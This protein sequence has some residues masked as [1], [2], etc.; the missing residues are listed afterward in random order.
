ME[1]LLKI[2]SDLRKS[3]AQLVLDQGELD[4][5]TYGEA[6][7]P[8][9][10][11]AIRANKEGLIEYLTLLDN[12]SDTQAA[13]P[14]Q[15]KQEAY[16]VS[17]AQGRMWMLCQY[18]EESKAYQMP[19]QVRLSGAYDIENFKKA[20]YAVIER[21]D[22]LRTVFFETDTGAVMQQVKEIED[23]QFS[24]DYHDLRNESDAEGTCHS[25]ITADKQVAFNLEQ[26]PLLRA[27]LFRLEEMEYEFYF[28]MHHIISDGWSMDILS[29]DVLA[30]YEAYQ[31]N[32]ESNVPELSIQYKDYAAWYRNESQQPAFDSHKKYWEEKLGGE[33]P[34]LDLPTRKQRP[35]IKTYKGAALQTYLSKEATQALNKWVQAHGGSL[36]TAVLAVYNVLFSKYTGQEDIMVGT[37][38]SG[39]DHSDLLNQIGLYVNTLVLRNSIDANDSFAQFYKKLCESTLNDFEHQAYSFDQIIEDLNIKGDPSRSALFDVIFTLQNRV[40]EDFEAT[41]IKDSESI[42]T[43]DDGTAKF[44]LQIIA[45]EEGEQLSLKLTYNTDVYGMGMLKRFLNHFKQLIP[46]LIDQSNTP[47]KRIEYLSEEERWEILGDFN[48]TTVAY[49]KDVTL[50][51]LFR[52][53]VSQTPDAVAVIYEDREWTYQELEDLSNKMAHFLLSNYEIYKGDFIGIRIPR[54]EWS[55]L[56]ILAILK[57][58]AAYVPIDMD[59]PTERIE[60][61]ESDSNCS[62]T[63][64]ADVLERFK[65]EKD[66]YPASVPELTLSPNQLAY[67]MYTSGSTGRPKGVMIEQMGIIRLVKNT[68]YVGLKRGTVVLGLS[69]FSFDGSTF[70]IYAALLNGGTLVIAPKD[71]Y[72]DLPKLD[73]LIN[74]YEVDVFFLT[75]VFFNAITDAELPSLGRLKYILFG[76]EKA[77]TPHAR[78]FKKLYPTVNVHNA[79][80]PT[81]NTTFSTYYAVEEGPSTV[82]NI[83]I[84]IPISNSTCY[85]LDTH[86]NIVP[87]G[88]TGELYLGGDGLARG[89]YNRPD[90][91]EERFIPSPFKS[92]ENLYKTGDLGRWL[93]DGTIEFLGRTDDQVKIRGHRIELGEIETTLQSKEGINE[94][95]VLVETSSEGEM[96]LVAY[97]V[98]ENSESI[99]NL[100]EFLKEK[101][102]NYMIPNVF[103]SLDAFPLTT[104]GKVDKKKLATY[105]KS[106]TQTGNDYVAPRS[107]TEEQL[108]AIWQTVLGREEMG[109]TDGFFELGGNSLKV[110]KMIS[111]IQQEFNIKIAVKRFY[112]N[113]TISGLAE[114][115]KENKGGMTD[116]IQ[117]IA[118]SKTGYPV[119]N[120]QLRIWIASQSEEGSM[121][122][123]MI[124]DY[125]VAGDLDVEILKAS[126]AHICNRHEALRTYFSVT[127]EGDVVQFIKDTIDI[128]SVFRFQSESSET[129]EQTLEHFKAAGFHLGNAPL[130]RVL[131][132]LTSEDTYVMSYVMHHIIGDFGSYEILIKEIQQ[133]YDALKHGGLLQVEPL[134][135]QNKDYVAWI[136]KKLVHNEFA[137][138]KAFLKTYLEKI[139]SKSNWINGRNA[140][141]FEGGA[142]SDSFDADLVQSLKKYSAEGGVGLMS[143]MSSALGVLIHKTTGQEDV[144]VGLPISLRNHPDLMQQVGLYLNMLPIRINVKDEQQ[145]THFLQ[146]NA[147]EQLQLM[148]AAFYPFDSIIEDFEREYNFNLAD[149]ID[150]YLNIVHCS[151]ATQSE[152]EFSAIT[153]TPKPQPTRKSKFPICFYLYEYD[154]HISFTI[155][156]QTEVFDTKEI[157]NLGNRFKKCLTQLLEQPTAEIHKISLIDKASIPSFNF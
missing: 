48:N 91:N 43:L 59:Y 145:V 112:E 114:I 137:P 36:F 45:R 16:P 24:I 117:P 150:V 31:N 50:V 106:G 113:P 29:R 2:L 109:V 79:Y 74:D 85:L 125:L 73:T 68:N 119:S 58:G 78:K 127:Q 46:A 21:H 99:K 56:S 97:Y 115:L 84:G 140:S 107:K 38:V 5:I 102:P 92:E 152:G 151:E 65:E 98:S 9:L 130:F 75:V 134:P 126:I 35:S 124:S 118:L 128:D 90:L 61:M 23:F 49:P 57:V 103:V 34:L 55:V 1:E 133:T 8:E 116:T 96:E 88:V 155:E 66:Q 69:N 44:D 52:D 156:Y 28:N 143:L 144:V 39:R 22:I 67:L 77:S 13:I 95:V 89:Y 139:Q 71:I 100:R 135:V 12:A 101:L 86:L 30:Y 19:S 33:I 120:E 142:F 64:D 157:S 26:G 111:L 15:P 87:I 83:P 17:S 132:L 3:N 7:A 10:L 82:K 81:E 146:E 138:Q 47:L 94:V 63:I 53:Q 32:T 54:S 110:F 6:I 121:A 148:D 149:R 141:D 122:H 60:Y 153:F 62:L 154:D 123:H 104:N 129:I 27:K 80:G 131:L 76:G 42:K 4:L 70:D 147:K 41:E 72:L 14:V 37:P 51:D 18:E 25:I 40:D 11:E 136:T 105:D 20:L 93:P 108:V